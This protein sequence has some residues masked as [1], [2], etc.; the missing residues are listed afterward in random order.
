MKLDVLIAWLSARGLPVVVHHRLAKVVD[1]RTRSVVGHI[2]FVLRDD[3]SYV[4]AMRVRGYAGRPYN[5]TELPE[6][7]AALV[8]L[9]GDP[10]AVLEF[11][12]RIDPV[13][14][15]QT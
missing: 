14:A 8:A 11:L 9:T 10:L 1:D 5:P 3:V 13:Q 6:F 4:E 2:D 15:G 12:A 7:D